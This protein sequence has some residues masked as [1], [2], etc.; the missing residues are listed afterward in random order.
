MTQ[1]IEKHMTS[2]NPFYCHWRQPRAV[3]ITLILYRGYVSRI[4]CPHLLE[5]HVCGS[6]YKPD[7]RSK[8]YVWQCGRCDGIVETSDKD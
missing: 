3:E 6:T 2:A 1:Y 5:D 4:V 7:D 8:C